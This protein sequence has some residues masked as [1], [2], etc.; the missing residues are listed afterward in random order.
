MPEKKS[1][2]EKTKKAAVEKPAVKKDCH[3]V[4]LIS[5]AKAAP[6]KK[7]EGKVNR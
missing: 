1:V 6:A 7:A 5:P 3:Q 4:R 2:S